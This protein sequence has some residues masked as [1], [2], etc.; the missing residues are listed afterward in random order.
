MTS[1]ERTSLKELQSLDIKLRNIGS[2]I[3]NFE[4]ELEELEAPTLKLGQEIEGLG[5]RLQELSLEKK[6]LELAILEK[7]DRLDKLEERMNQVRNIREETAVHAES[8]MVKRALKNDEQESLAVTEQIRK[9][10]DRM[11]EKT[12]IHTESLAE[13][14]PLRKGMIS[15][16]EGAESN[17]EKLTQEREDLAETLDADERAVYEQITS[18]QG[19]MAVSELTEDGACGHCYSVVPL[20]RQNEIRHS[21]E[22]IRCEECGVIL[23]P[24]TQV[25][26]SGNDLES[27]AIEEIEPI[28]SEAETSDSEIA[29]VSDS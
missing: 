2:T 29:E 24:E 11:N 26:S 16:R 3:D 22:L 28:M 5:K 15:E 20:Q 27:G 10:T 25:V 12:T 23:T 6:R 4:V 1:K 21:E 9:M 7:R 18:G 13:M 14:E 17:L 19:R 8:D